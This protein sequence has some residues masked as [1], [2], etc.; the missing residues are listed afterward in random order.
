MIPPVYASVGE[1]VTLEGYAI[2][3]GRRIAQVQFSLDEG[4][5]WTTYETPGTTDERWVHWTFAYTP[6]QPGDYRL[7]VR[8]VNEDGRPSPEWSWVDLHVA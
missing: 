1:S 2:D 4:D 8:S 6:E 5:H 7:A 3:Y